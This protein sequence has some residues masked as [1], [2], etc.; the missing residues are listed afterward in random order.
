VGGVVLVIL[1]TQDSTTTYFYRVKT[2]TDF[3]NTFTVDPTGLLQPTDV[4]TLVKGTSDIRLIG[5]VNNNPSNFILYRGKAGARIIV[6]LWTPLS[7]ATAIKQSIPCS[8]ATP[9]LP[10]PPAEPPAMPVYPFSKPPDTWI[11]A[12][13]KAEQART[14]GHSLVAFPAQVLDLFHTVM[15]EIVGPGQ[16]PLK[17]MRSSI[18]M[19]RI[20][21]AVFRPN[22][23]LLPIRSTNDWV[24]ELFEPP[25]SGPLFAPPGFQ[26][27]EQ[28]V[29]H[30]MYPKFL[31]AMWDPSSP[32][33]FDTPYFEAFL[34]KHPGVWNNETQQVE[35][36]QP[37][38]HG[39]GGSDP[40]RGPSAGTSSSPRGNDT[41]LISNSDSDI[42][43]L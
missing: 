2:S 25:S 7:S 26:C 41:P 4:S 8:F 32:T 22:E 24:G 19:N 14:W 29:A 40:S 18:F 11:L 17:V 31:D 28:L 36:Y 38:A 16:S 27:P 15:L 1:K 3:R 9:P 23:G 30:L 21:Q 33:S 10:D 20:R 42:S 5:C 43:H 13:D 35:K 12:K 39:A 6:V 37:A 34:R